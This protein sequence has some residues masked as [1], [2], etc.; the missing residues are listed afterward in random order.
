MDSDNNLP[1]G[2]LPLVVSYRGAGDGL[3]NE[4]RS[5]LGTYW[6]TST[7]IFS[8]DGT[9]SCFLAQQALE[10]RTTDQS[11]MFYF[12]QLRDLPQR[13]LR[14]LEHRD[15]L[16][17]SSASFITSLL[18]HEVVYATKLGLLLGGREIPYRPCL[19]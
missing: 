6:A 10:P 18:H 2:I 8:S 13:L 9:C 17:C 5:A 4:K 1:L 14:S 19:R 12:F 15:Q 11:E 7:S 16:L 3:L